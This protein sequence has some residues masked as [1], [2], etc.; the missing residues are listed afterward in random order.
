MRKIFIGLFLSTGLFSAFSNEQL[1]KREISWKG[2]FRTSFL[3]SLDKMLAAI[4]DEPSRT[5]AIV[6]TQRGEIFR[7]PTPAMEEFIRLHGY[8]SE[9]RPIVARFT[10]DAED[11]NLTREVLKEIHEK[12]IDPF[13]REITAAE[14]ITK[15]L[16]YRDLKPGDQIS[17]PV[18]GA[19][20]GATYMPYIVDEVLDLWHGMPAFGLLPQDKEGIPILLFRGT[21]LSLVTERGWASVISDLEIH[22]PG[23]S[24]F[25]SG[26]S[27]IRAW[28]EKAEKSCSKAR[29]MGFSL[30][31]ILAAYTILYEGDL[32]SRDKTSFSF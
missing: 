27:K 10:K 21:D 1:E 5:Y 29:V 7:S 23:L 19:Q 16:A 3:K 20:S 2:T 25:Q 17:L 15:V 11:L 22:D 4:F 30:G 14:V 8:F 9:E 32:I 28:L 6:P 31:G 26:Q 24:A 18:L 13:Q 12:V